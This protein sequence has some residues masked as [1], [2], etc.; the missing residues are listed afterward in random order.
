MEVWAELVV[1]ERKT[2]DV[3]TIKCGQEKHQGLVLDFMK[4]VSQKWLLNLWLGW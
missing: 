3:V 4:E 2:L 1:A